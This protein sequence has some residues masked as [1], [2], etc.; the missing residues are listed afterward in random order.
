MRIVSRA[1]LVVS[2]LVI[3]CGLTAG[4]SSAGPGDKSPQAKQPT[5]EERKAEL[6]AY[7]QQGTS[8]GGQPPTVA[9]GGVKYS[10]LSLEFNNADDCKYF[11]AK[12]DGIYVLTRFQQFAEIM[13]RQDD[14]KAEAKVVSCIPLFRWYDWAADDVTAPPVEP[15]R[16]VTEAQNRDIESVVR[17]GLDGLTGKGV[18]IAVLDTGIDFRHPDFIADDGSSRL[19]SFWDTTEVWKDIGRASC[20]ERV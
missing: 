13:Y 1:A 17:G 4:L 12:D 15:V 6:Q 16:K 8:G 9:V 11:D 3:A 10:V 2:G 18:I 20:R 5:L 7:L 14:K 19:L